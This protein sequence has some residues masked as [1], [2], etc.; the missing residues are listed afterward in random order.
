MCR[1]PLPEKDTAYAISAIVQQLDHM[2][3]SLMSRVVEKIVEELESATHLDQEC[4]TTGKQTK[5][6]LSDHLAIFLISQRRTW[7]LRS[8]HRDIASTT[9]TTECVQIS[10]TQYVW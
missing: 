3:V 6:A 1:R 2:D 9:F 7:K 4:I 8:C 10:F 5:F